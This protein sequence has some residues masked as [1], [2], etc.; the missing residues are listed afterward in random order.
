MS[1]LCIV[2]SQILHVLYFTTGLSVS[3]TAQK[4]TEAN[5]LPPEKPGD[6][7]S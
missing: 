6:C 1:L 7:S 3:E 5:I 2:N 4:V